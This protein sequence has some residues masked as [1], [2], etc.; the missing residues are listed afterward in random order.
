M[1]YGRPIAEL[2][3]MTSARFEA[4]VLPAARPVVL[5][6]LASDWPSVRAAETGG[7][8]P[9]LT[10]MDVG[11]PCTL[12][13]GSPE[14]EGRFGY[15]AGLTGFNFT[16][17]ATTLLAALDRLA[18]VAYAPDPPALAVQA[19]PAHDALPAFAPANP[20]PLIDAH[21]SPRLWIG[22]RVVVAAHHDLSRN[23]AVCVAG[24]RQ[25]TVFPPDA[26][27]DLYIGPLEFSP[28]GTPISMVDGVRPDLARYPRFRRAMEVAEIAELAPG[29][30]IY[31]PYL[32]WH[33]VR[34]LGPLNILANYW[35]NETPPTQPGLSPMD[36]LMHARLAFSA[37]S[38]EQRAAWRT[39]IDYLV[40]DESADLNHIP[41][42]RRGIMGRI[43]DQ[44]R[45]KLRR[46]LGELLGR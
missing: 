2:Q 7:I 11:Q 19:L 21:A 12:F 3:G 44:A 36:V 17:S 14:I 27:R 37:A 46:Q 10:A 40:F 38:T 35:W 25:F 42:G 26:V 6:G 22:N 24:R 34:S 15:D 30:A 39:M 41:H 9:Y 8:I 31:I 18:A 29:D 23:L 13:E 45:T 28:A 20:A 32:W 5:R 16:R 4:E 33:Q 43:G 1:S